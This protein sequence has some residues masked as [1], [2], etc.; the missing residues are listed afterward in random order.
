MSKVAPPGSEQPKD[1]PER[2]RLAEL[3]P[4]FAT[5]VL[6]PASWI[7]RRVES[8][9]FTPQL[10]VRRL[11]SVDFT[12]EADFPPYKEGKNGLHTYFLP[13]G[14]LRKW[15]PLMKLDLLKPAAPIREHTC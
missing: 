8:L 1:P 2:R 14:L 4:S 5:A 13:V 9:S 12:V 10:M 3:S 7:H 6:E 15:P 11:I